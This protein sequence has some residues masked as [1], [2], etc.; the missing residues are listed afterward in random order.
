MASDFMESQ[1]FKLFSTTADIG[2]ITWADELPVLFEQA[3]AALFHIITNPQQISPKQSIN[4]QVTASD[5]P[6]LVVNWLSEIIYRQ[7]ILEMLF[8]RAEIKE[9]YPYRLEAALFGEFYDPKRHVI[10]REVKAATYHKFS[11]KQDLQGQWRL[12]LIVDI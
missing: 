2:L 7:E 10:K 5:W 12:R 4:V 8:T 1:Q 11:L 9:I 3:A 6:E